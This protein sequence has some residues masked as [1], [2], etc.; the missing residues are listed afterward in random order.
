MVLDS[1]F[2]RWNSSAQPASFRAQVHLSSY[3]SSHL[4]KD[5]MAVAIEGQ[6]KSW[7]SN[8]KNRFSRSLMRDDILAQNPEFRRQLLWINS[9]RA[10]LMSNAAQQALLISQSSTPGRLLFISK[11]ASRLMR[12]MAKAYIAR[13]KLPNPQ[14][15]PMQVNEKSSNFRDANKSKSSFANHW[16][17]ISTLNRGR[18]VEIPIIGN[19]FSKSRKGRRANTFSL[20]QR[21]GDWFLLSTQYLAPT[22]WAKYKTDVLGVDVGLSSLIATSEGDLYGRGFL[23]KLRKYDQQIQKIQHGLQEAGEARLSQCRRYKKV[24]SRLKGWLKTTIQKNVKQMLEQRQPRKIIVEDL[25]FSGGP[26]RLSRRMNRLLRNFGQYY[27][28]QS[29][30]ERQQEFQFELEIVDPAYSSQ[31]CSSCGF[32]HS[33]NRKTEKFKCLSCGH[34]GHADVN[35]AKNLSRRSGWEARSALGRLRNLWAQITQD[36]MERSRSRLMSMVSSGLPEK[37][38]TVD[39]ARAGL[40]ALAERKGSAS[41]LTT[42][43]KRT[44]LDAANATTLEGLLIGLERKSLALC[45]WRIDPFQ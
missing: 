29:V 44:L 39:C 6:A 41:R 42:L 22:P 35:A 25:V 1:F 14:A 26:G 16:L 45:S 19:A 7:V 43:S 33:D 8:L 9:M 11:T 32:L 3:S 31:T 34:L 40:R 28:L 2:K 30:R 17:R 10:W 37:D 27:F 23:Q 36:W 13:F 18:K 20:I 15:L 24:I 38:R 4:T 12:K 21:Q 5:L